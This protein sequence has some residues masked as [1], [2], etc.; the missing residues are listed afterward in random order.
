MQDTFF[1][2]GGIAIT[3]Q[4]AFFALGLIAV[5]LL[6]ALV[7]SVAKSRR[8][9]EE[10]AREQH[11]RVGEVEERMAEVARVQAELTGRVQT[12]A[13]VF[14]TRQSDLARMLSERLDQVGQRLGTNLNEQT[15]TTFESLSKLNER[16][17]VIDNA[18]RNL[19]ALSDQ[20]GSLRAILANKQARGAFGQGRMEAIVEDGLP[21]GAFEF[22]ATLSNRNRPDC[23]IRLPSDDRV[24]VIDA[25]FPLEAVAAFRDARDEAARKAGAAQLKADINRHV[26]KIADSY[27]LPGE[28]QDIALMFV[29]SES[30]YADLHEH[31]EDVV[32]KAMRARVVLVSPSLLMLAIQ[33]VQAIVKDAR[34]R[35]QAHLI[36]AEVRLLMDD[37]GRLRER[38]HNLQR[39][40]GQTASDLD[41]LLVSTDKLTKRAAKIEALELGEA[42][43]GATSTADIVPVATRRDLFGTGR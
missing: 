27:F 2:I 36:Q 31:F 19:S 37:L 33:V 7:A 4:A 25:K 39:H 34:M 42:E 8:A 20:V 35:E 11:F 3:N 28:T 23:V 30:I 38:A 13:E 40:F 26:Q 29:P 17:A 32:Q 41:Q 16:L 18:Q 10:A 14:G 1:V 43:G 12:V 22:Q 9:S 15:K 5:G 21:K 24:L 6:I